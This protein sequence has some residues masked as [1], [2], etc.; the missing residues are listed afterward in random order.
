[1]AEMAGRGHYNRTILFQDVID[2]CQVQV[3]RVMAR[4]QYQIRIRRAGH[5]AHEGLIAA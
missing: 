5:S 3:V 2:G 4:D 1:M